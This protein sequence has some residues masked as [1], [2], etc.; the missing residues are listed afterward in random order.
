MVK[1]ALPMKGAWVPSPIRELS[2]TLCKVLAEDLKIKQRA[3]SSQL[4]DAQGLWTGDKGELGSDEQVD[5]R[6]N[7]SE[8]CRSYT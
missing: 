7:A 1:A 8:A 2:H 6:Q 4:G 3:L 5:L